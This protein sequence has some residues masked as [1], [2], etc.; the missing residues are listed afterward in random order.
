MKFKTDEN[1]PVEVL[2]LLRQMGH[3]AQ[4]AEEEWLNGRPDVDVFAA[5]QKENRA[6]ITLDLDFSDIRSYPPADHFG[7][8]VLRPRL[9]TITS[10]EMLATRGFALLGKET[11]EKRLWIVDEHQVRIRGGNP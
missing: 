10:I 9:Q 11:L 3:D 8:I 7:T 6:M 1:V 5:C 4:S 2:E